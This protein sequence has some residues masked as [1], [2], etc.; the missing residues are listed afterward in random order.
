M[1]RAQ[2]VR[3]VSL[4][5]C[6]VGFSDEGLRGE[7]EN[8]IRLRGVNRLGELRR[9]PHVAFDVRDTFFQPGLGEK[10]RLRGRRQA[11]ARD[12]RAETQQPLAEPGAFKTRVPGHKN[13]AAGI[14]IAEKY[15][16]GTGLQFGFGSHGGMPDF[17]RLSRALCLRPKAC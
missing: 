8:E 3:F 15:A 12:A 10:R 2:H 17:T 14:D 9:V 13:L 5:R 6:A 1:H 11:V 7:M 4:N 16:G